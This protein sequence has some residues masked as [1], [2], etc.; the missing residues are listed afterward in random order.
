MKRSMRRNILCTFVCAVCFLGFLVR[1]EAKAAEKEQ[2]RTEN[3]SFD[4]SRFLLPEDA[5]GLV[6]VEGFAKKSGKECYDGGYVSD[7]SRY[8]RARVTAFVKGADGVWHPKLQ[9]AAVFGWGGMSN[10][11]KSGDGSTPIGLWRANTP[12]GRE[13]FEMGFPSDYV[14]ISSK[15]R[16]QYW[17]DIRNRLEESDSLEAQ[18]GERLWEDWAKDIYAY[19]L[20]TGFNRNGSYPGSGSALFLHCTKEGKAS[21][22]GCVAMDPV[23][24]K[25]ILKLYARG[26]LYVAQAPEG[27]FDGVYHAFREDG[28]AAPGTFGASEK[29]MPETKTIILP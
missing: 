22:A 15:K 21:T 28:A 18:S 17:S 26:A 19:S 25:E 8:N 27:A 9:S 10:H 3:L 2:I 11:R 7:L 14:Q 13:A 12:F 23:A 4:V 20:D 1:G 16:T 5:K 6:V 24:M 29:E